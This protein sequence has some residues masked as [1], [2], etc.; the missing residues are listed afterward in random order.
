MSKPDTYPVPESDAEQAKNKRRNRNSQDA[1]PEPMAGSHR[2]K[3][4]N[5]TR[6]NNAE[7]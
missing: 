1:N 6:H 5:H 2:V 3:Q 7:G 4:Q